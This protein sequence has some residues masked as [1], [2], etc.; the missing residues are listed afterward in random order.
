MLLGVVC[1]FLSGLFGIGGG[2]VL[3][4]SFVFMLYGYGFFHQAVVYIVSMTSLAVYV[5]TGASSAYA[6]LRQ[7]KVLCLFVDVY[8][9]FGRFHL[10][11]IAN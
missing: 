1:G 10:W 3:L 2:V 9:S 5:I 7:S 4:P 8:R 6:Y 11:D